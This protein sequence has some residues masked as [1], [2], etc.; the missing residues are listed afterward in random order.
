MQLAERNGSGLSALAPEQ[1]K[2]PLNHRP[3]LEA[4]QGVRQSRIGTPELLAEFGEVGA[5]S[6]SLIHIPIQIGK[7]K[8]AKK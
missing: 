3:A 4:T 1:I 6:A 8:F 5:Q 2:E 7:R